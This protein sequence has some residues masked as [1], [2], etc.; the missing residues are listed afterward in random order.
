MCTCGG[1]PPFS[2]LTI[3]RAER[4][5]GINDLDHVKKRE[6]RGERDDAK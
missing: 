2:V 6:K 5:G 4:E 3:E 1:G